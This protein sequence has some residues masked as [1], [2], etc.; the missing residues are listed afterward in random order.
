[1]AAVQDLVAA[2]QR[3]L[4]LFIRRLKPSLSL[5]PDPAFADRLELLA[6]RLQ[7]EWG[8]SVDLRL[9]NSN[10]P[11]PSAL[12]DEIHYIVSEAFVNAAR[13]S[14]ASV[15]R[16]ELE[17]GETQVEITV[18]DDGHGFPFLG[19]YDGAALRARAIGP[20]TLRERVASLG[21]T[22]MID[23]S[24]SGSCLEI[25]LPCPSPEGRHAD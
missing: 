5:E 9:A 1:M 15:V 2:E 20:V 19:R 7:L 8:I 4:R 10:R 25:A 11:I 13:H 14:G 12:S 17:V 6:Q 18:T 23:S 21:G 22:F 3:H 24:E 16:V